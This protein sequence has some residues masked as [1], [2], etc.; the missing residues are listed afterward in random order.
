[1]PPVSCLH[2]SYPYRVEVNSTSDSPADGFWHNEASYTVYGEVGD[3]ITITVRISDTENS[4]SKP[5]STEIEVDGELR[6]FWY[7]F[8]WL[9][10]IL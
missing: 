8:N 7:F 2:S 1:L 9:S 6:K 3:T 10:K 5:V 4:L